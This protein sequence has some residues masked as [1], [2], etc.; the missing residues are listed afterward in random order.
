MET[1]FFKE[2]LEGINEGKYTCQTKTV[3]SIGFEETRHYILVTN[4]ETKEKYNI[5]IKERQV[6]MFRFLVDNYDVEKS[7]EIR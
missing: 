3:V 1:L 6:E 2:L 7:L 5:R 4:E